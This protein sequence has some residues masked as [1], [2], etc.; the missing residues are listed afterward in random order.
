MR[1]LRL[2][3]A[4]V[5]LGLGVVVWGT[6]VPSHDRDWLPEQAQLPFAEFM[7][8]RI[9]LHN[10]RDAVYRTRDDYDVH[11]GNR[12]IRENDVVSAW[13]VVDQL[14]TGRGTAH[15]FVSF[16][17]RDGTTLSVS[18][19]ARREVGEPYSPWQGL[20]RR[21]ELIYVLATEHDAVGLRANIRKHPVWL[22]RLSLTPEQSQA[23]FVAFLRKM[24]ALRELPEFYDTA[25]NAC[26]DSVMEQLETVVPGTNAPDWRVVLPGYSDVM[27]YERKMIDGSLP[28]DDLKARSRINDAAARFQDSPRFSEE[29]RR[30]LP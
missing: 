2:L 29:I 10:V 24:N 27:L 7:D 9:V 12:T 1:K 6:T 28:F 5:L 22:Y 11:Y 15:T 8:G 16:G 13:Y 4:A 17:L 20:L 21:Y 19:E 18:V 25:T 26:A 14:G 30:N 3:W 23:F